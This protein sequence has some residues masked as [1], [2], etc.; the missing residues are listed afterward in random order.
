MYKYAD[1]QLGLVQ[2]LQVPLAARQLPWH[3]CGRGRLS[4]WLSLVSFLLLQW[5]D[6]QKAQKQPA[7]RRLCLAAVNCNVTHWIL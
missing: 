2:G 5:N 3:S 4:L 7:G 6:S 1:S